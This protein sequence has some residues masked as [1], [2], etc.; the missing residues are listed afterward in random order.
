MAADFREL[1][2]ARIGH[3]RRL[4]LLLG[5][6]VGG[7]AVLGALLLLGGSRLRLE[8]WRHGARGVLGGPK[9]TTASDSPRQILDLSLPDARYVELGMPSQ[10]RAWNGDDFGVAASKLLELAAHHPEQLPRSASAKSG[11]TFARI[12]SS[13]DRGRLLSPSIPLAKRLT[14]AWRC[15]SSFNE[16]VRLYVSG[17]KANKV[18]ENDVAELITPGL[19]IVQVTLNVANEYDSIVSMPDAKHSAGVKV[20]ARIR[21]DCASLVISMVEALTLKQQLPVSTRL[22]LAESYQT[23]I[24]A[25]MANLSGGSRLD[26]LRRLDELAVDPTLREL[27]MPLLILRNSSY[28]AAE[29]DGDLPRETWPEKTVITERIPLRHKGLSLLVSVFLN[30]NT[31][32]MVV[33]TGCELMSLPHKVAVE[34]GVNL[35]RARNVKITIADGSVVNAKLATF[36]SVRVGRFTERNV[37]C[38][39]APPSQ[40]NA[41]LLL[42]RAFL[43]R[44]KFELTDT[45]MILSKADAEATRPARR[46]AP[47]PKKATRSS[48]GDESQE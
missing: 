18:A 30:G 23:A 47:R 34:C 1:A 15:V 38:V 8:Q 26:V 3:G 45:D 17:C 43:G 27:Q 22:S 24:P 21:Q 39:V 5:V 42:G 31:R 29:S 40:V 35:D 7:I 46:Q 20:L 32:W 4:L 12:V 6:A 2:R 19:D 14:D 25:L 11:K 48:T 41:P 16:I 37:I 9:Q 33:D 10:D 28:G 44:F 13:E 36:D